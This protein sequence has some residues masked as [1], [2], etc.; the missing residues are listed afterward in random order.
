MLVGLMYCCVLRG[1]CN[2]HTRVIPRSEESQATT[3]S[4]PRTMLQAY[5]GQ[6]VLSQQNEHLLLVFG[7]SSSAAFFFRF[8]SDRVHYVSICVR[9]MHVPCGGARAQ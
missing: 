8:C 5:A 1:S 2:N 4:S 9:N 7:G 6:E 3:T